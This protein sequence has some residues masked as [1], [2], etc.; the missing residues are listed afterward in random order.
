M[1]ALYMKKVFL[2]GFTL[3]CTGNIMFSQQSAPELK[4]Q[5]SA[6]EIL[7]PKPGPAPRINGPKVFGVRPKHPIVYTIPTSGNRPM[8]FSAP[9]L[10]AGVKLDA[11]TGRLSG[12]IAK[13]GTYVIT[14]QAKNKVGS[15]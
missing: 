7:T 12:S 9:K 10:P 1:V 6:A 14:F 13:P 5:A 2:L 8:T 11:K 4:I 3:F 15:A